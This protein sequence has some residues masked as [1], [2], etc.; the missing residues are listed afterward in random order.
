MLENHAIPLVGGQRLDGAD[1]GNR[2]VVHEDV[3]A[4]ER[5]PC[6]IHHGGDGLFV[7]HVGCDAE[8]PS[9]PVADG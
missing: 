3:D 8:R 7:A 5:L 9:A 2:G 6:A 1:G 4:P